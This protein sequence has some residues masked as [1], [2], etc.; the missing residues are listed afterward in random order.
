[1]NMAAEVVP[2]L[3]PSAADYVVPRR[4]TTDPASVSPSSSSSDV[5]SS[6]T[7]SQHVE[8]Q[9]DSDDVNVNEKKT[10]GRFLTAKYPKHQMGLI[11]R[12]LIVEDWIDEQ[13]KLLFDVVSRFFSQATFGLK[14]WGQTSLYL[15]DA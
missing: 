6:T 11:R 15:T 3:S 8:F 12:R 9:V 5:T 10:R 4:T 13:L 7:S 14:I 1:M 2:G